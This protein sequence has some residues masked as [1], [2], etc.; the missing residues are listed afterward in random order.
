ME[1]T[2]GLPSDEYR[3]VCVY[4]D[5]PGAPQCNEPAALHVMV[6]DQKYGCVSLAT[7][8]KHARIARAAGSYRMEHPFEGFCG[9]PGTLWNEQH[10]V[11]VLDDSGQEPAR[12]EAA[13]AVIA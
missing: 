13:E 7:C 4:S 5:E 11:C 2:V 10:N 3:A 6:D 12:A 8:T 1:P 9:F